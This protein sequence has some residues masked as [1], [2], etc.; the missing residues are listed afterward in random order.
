[1][2]DKVFIAYLAD[3]WAVFVTHHSV[4]FEYNETEANESERLKG[5]ITVI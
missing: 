5:L 3:L 4:E 1:M 2:T